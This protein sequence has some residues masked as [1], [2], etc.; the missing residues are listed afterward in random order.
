MP[1]HYA[2]L[3]E[4]LD[5]VITDAAPPWLRKMVQTVERVAAA[6]PR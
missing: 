4:Q 2:F 6:P 3:C 5:V 1:R